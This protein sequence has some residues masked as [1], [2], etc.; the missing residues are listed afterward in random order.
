MKVHK[1]DSLPH[2]IT[3]MELAQLNIAAGNTISGMTNEEVENWSVQQ[4]PHCHVW[5]DNTESKYC[6]D[7][8]KGG[9]DE[10]AR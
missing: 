5:H 8:C 10:K 3:V 6:S 4:C 7:W 1:F 9:N 2:A